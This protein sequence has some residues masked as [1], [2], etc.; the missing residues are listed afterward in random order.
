MQLP[1]PLIR[2]FDIP[3]DALARAMPEAASPLWDIDKFRQAT[4]E[5]HR[6]TRSIVFESILSGWL[7]GQKAVIE[8]QN[9]A[10]PE[11]TRLAY[12]CAGLFAAHRGGKVVRLLLAEL[13]PRGV[14]TVHRDKGAALTE[15][16]RCHLPIITNKGVQ[17]FIDMIPHML[18][19]GTGYEFDNTRRHSVENNSDER[20]IHLL[21]DVM[22]AALADSAL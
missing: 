17:F 21:C 22:P 14:I 5:V 12:A 16:H 18:E 2:L 6:N 19:T 4:H 1:E 8:R 10:P 11:L 20:R 9:Y 3:V 13:A 7:P 15:V